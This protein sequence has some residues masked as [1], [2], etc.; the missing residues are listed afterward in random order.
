VK[1]PPIP[2]IPFFS[3][4]PRRPNEKIVSASRGSLSQFI[5]FL[6]ADFLADD[7]KSPALLSF[8]PL[9][10]EAFQGTP[11]FALFFLSFLKSPYGLSPSRSGESFTPGPQS[12]LLDQ[13]ELANPTSVP[14]WYG[15]RQV[16]LSQPQP[17]RFSLS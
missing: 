15:R 17:T 16:G 13:L 12:K 10:R 3:T 8:F 9:P 2:S 11:G 6:L 14:C 5:V 7:P 4:V 1:F